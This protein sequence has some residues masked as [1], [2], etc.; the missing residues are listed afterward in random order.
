MVFQLHA[1][2]QKKRARTKYIIVI[3]ILPISN[4]TYVQLSIFFTLKH[5]HFVMA[6]WNANE[7][8]LNTWMPI[9]P[10]NKIELMHP[11]NGTSL[12]TRKQAQKTAGILEAT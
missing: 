10:W 8:C 1:Y 4:S 7:K 2:K 11:E 9:V 5:R 3:M 12:R 6:Q